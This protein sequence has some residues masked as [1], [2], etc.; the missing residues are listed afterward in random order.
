MKRFIV[1]IFLLTT[2]FG[3]IENDLPLPVITPRITGMDVKGASE[4][5]INSE[6]QCVTI[7]LDETTD[8]R[9]VKINSISFAD[10]RTTTDFDTSITHDLSND[11]TITLSI[12]QDYKWKI[13]TRQP[14][15][16]ISLR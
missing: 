11:I 8:I 12:Y 9:N 10:E 5:S 15:S 14:I 3:C 13:I 2:F 4:I 6:Q 16:T 7:T 1:Y